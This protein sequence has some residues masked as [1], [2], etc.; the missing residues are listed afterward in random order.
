MRLGARFGAGMVLQAAMAFHAA[1][2]FRFNFQ[3]AHSVIASEAKQSRA[4]HAALDCRVASLLAM[5]VERYE[6]A[7]SR[8][9]SPELCIFITL[10]KYRGRGED[11][12]A[13][14]TRALA[15]R[16]IARARKPQ[17]QA[18]ITPAFPAQW[19]YGLYALSSVNH[20]VCHRHRRDARASSAT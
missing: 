20:S 7:P 13:A 18:V 1:C 12:V 3:T 6:S 2:P 11:R 19:F 5:T 16:R 14:C 15:Q 4:M 17:V 8:R 9:I 10:S